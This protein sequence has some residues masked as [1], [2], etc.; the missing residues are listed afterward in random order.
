MLS[1]FI[2]SIDLG[3][4][5]MVHLPGTRVP[6]PTTVELKFQASP[7]KTAPP[8]EGPLALFR[9]FPTD[10]KVDGDRLGSVGVVQLNA[11]G[12]RITGDD[13]RHLGARQ[14]GVGVLLVSQVPGPQFDLIVAA[15]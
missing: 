2:L 11:E 7:K 6:D 12:A 4:D 8:G 10:R 3:G 5:P 9:P 13:L 1:I 15:G 14:Q